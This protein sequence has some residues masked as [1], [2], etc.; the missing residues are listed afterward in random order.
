MARKSPAFSFYP[1][2]WVLGTIGLTFEQQ[3]VY[4]RMLCY[5]WAAGPSPLS[6]YV[7]ACGGM[8]GASAEHVASI[9]SAIAATKFERDG[10]LYFN[11]RLE[12][13]R[14]KQRARSNKAK[15]AAKGRWT[16]SR[17][18]SKPP[19]SRCSEHAASIAQ[20]YAPAMPSVSVS[21]D[22][23]HQGSFLDN[24]GNKPPMLGASPQEVKP[25]RKARATREPFRAPTAEEVKAYCEERGNQVN[26]NGFWNYY[27][28][29]GWRVGRNPMK[30]WRAAVRTWERDSNKPGLVATPKVKIETFRE[31][32]ERRQREAVLKVKLEMLGLSA[33]QIERL[34]HLPEHDAINEARNIQA[35]KKGESLRIDFES[36]N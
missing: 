19:E 28:A 23:K 5:Q 11:A 2:A 36:G 13:E 21:V 33:Q 24:T 10:D 1:D 7:H 31:R 20:A 25:P 29:N 34:L 9:C 3:G 16:D 6:A 15:A 30:D 12:E 4:L 14:D 22:H 35:N 8:L 32:D 27:T 18:A 26:P 17:L